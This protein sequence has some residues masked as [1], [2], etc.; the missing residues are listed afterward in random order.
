MPK[1]TRKS[2]L[3]GLIRD[4]NEDPLSLE[5]LQRLW[6]ADYHAD[7]SQTQDTNTFSVESLG[8]FTDTQNNSSMS[9]NL[10]QMLERFRHPALIVRFD[11]RIEAMNLRA[12]R[13]IDTDP[14]D[15]IDEIGYELNPAEGLSQRIG[16]FLGASRNVQSLVEL[17]QTVANES[18]RAATLAAFRSGRS[19]S[20]ALLF[21]IDP[22][23]KGEAEAM[24]IHSFGLTL[25]EAEILG[26]FLNGGSLREIAEDR[27]RS[28]TTVRT[29]FHAIMTK[30]GVQTQAEL[31]RLALGISQF[32]ADVEPL[33]EVASHP[34]RRQ[35][36][37]LRPGGRCVDV[38]QAGD[39]AGSVVIYLAEC[40]LN[41]FA[42]MVEA[43]FHEAGLCVVSVSRPGYG[44]TSPSPEGSNDLECMAA[45]VEAVIDQLGF[46]PV[47]IA[48]H[49]TS[50]GF[51][52]ALAAARPNL[53][54]RVVVFAGTVP[55]PYIDVRLTHAPFAAALLRARSASPHLFGLIVRTSGAAWRR[56]GTRRFNSLNLSRSVVDL[57]VARSEPCVEEFDQALG[58]QFASGYA[59]LE[60]DLLLTTDDWSVHVRKSTAPAILLHGAKDPVTNITTVRRFAQ[61]HRNV[62]VLQIPDAG[63]LLHHTHTDMFIHVLRDGFLEGHA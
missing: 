29:Q 19:G 49:G 55:R 22:V 41:T 44:A 4:V 59:R 42:A 46:R 21:V 33:A 38:S 5:N 57:A 25:A 3:R 12:R 54:E 14:G 36:Q 61:E 50:A 11:G 17:W 30:F 37:V 2:G 13:S 45:D 28:H 15:M 20:T 34:Y 48:G 23:W 1:K 56:L 52:F 18:Q 24:A 32:I 58:A 60:A 63:Y 16:R 6:Q 43:K 51:A 8:A 26:A 27:G 10:G 62:A 7:P 35:V 31:V 47:V 39:F 53:V 40:T 9:A